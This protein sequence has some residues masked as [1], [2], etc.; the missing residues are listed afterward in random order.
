MEPLSK[1][2][3][4]QPQRVRTLLRATYVDDIVTGAK[5]EDSA[6]KG[7][8]DGW[9]FQFMEVCDQLKLTA[10]ADRSDGGHT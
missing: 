2:S 5:D 7:A 4:S 9:K 8:S 1:H 6:I 10:K 3:T